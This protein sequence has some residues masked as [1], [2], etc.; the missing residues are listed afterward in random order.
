MCTSLQFALS[1]LLEGAKDLAIRNVEG[2]YRFALGFGFF[3]FLTRWRN[4]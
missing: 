1:A 4:G 2:E 3:S